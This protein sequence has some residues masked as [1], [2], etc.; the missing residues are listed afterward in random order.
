MN[1]MAMAEPAMASSES[2]S[3]ESA[4]APPP[5][6]AGLGE[7]FL[8]D[9]KAPSPDGAPAPER[10]LLKDGD[11]TLSSPSS[12]FTTLAATIKET[13]LTLS[14]EA[15]IDSE[16]VN[17]NPVYGRGGNAPGKTVRRLHL[18]ARVPSA[19][20][21]AAFA[22]LT[23][24]PGAVVTRQSSNVQDVTSQYIDVSAR[25]AVL[26]STEAALTKLMARAGT[27]KEVLEIQR[28]LTRVINEKESN[29]GQMKFFE[30]ASAMSTLRVALEE[31]ETRLDGPRPVKVGRVWATFLRAMGSL[32]V[33][34]DAAVYSVVWAVPVIGGVLLAKTVARRS[35]VVT[36]GMV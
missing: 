32:M 12:T 25:H 23:A 36:D 8:S 35:A 30:T 4:G 9:L 1:K 13:I 34:V 28:E 31:E 3:Y 29:K 6:H 2:M 21:D 15:Y 5:V 26:A 27:T 24:L 22:T 14:P 10:M 33:L 19:L 7:S 18:S 20:F 17:A 16:S 11:I